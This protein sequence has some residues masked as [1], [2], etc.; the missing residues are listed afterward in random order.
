VHETAAWRKPCSELHNLHSSPNI[1]ED[2]ITDDELGR[3]F[4]I[5]ENTEDWLV[6][7]MRDLGA[8]SRIK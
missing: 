6:T 2:I 3:S 4:R 1:L 5:M 7:L 8:V